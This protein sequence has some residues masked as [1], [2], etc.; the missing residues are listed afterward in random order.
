MKNW[1]ETLVANSISP[2]QNL[3]RENTFT[4]KVYKRELPYQ[5]YFYHFDDI[6][7]LG[8]FKNK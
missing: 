8:T 1:P 5:P 3:N 2:V 4:S 6:N 7:P